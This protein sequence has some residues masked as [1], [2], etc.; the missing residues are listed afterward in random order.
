M[1]PLLTDRTGQQSCFSDRKLNNIKIISYDMIYENIKHFQKFLKKMFKKL[2][3]YPKIKVIFLIKVKR[4]LYINVLAHMILRH[5][6]LKLEV[7]GYTKV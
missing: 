4:M 2:C 6:L 5:T 3:F 1:P 7:Y